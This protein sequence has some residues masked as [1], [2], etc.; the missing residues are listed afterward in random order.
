[1]LGESSRL[2]L[3]VDGS[4]TTAAYGSVSAGGI[5]TPEL[6]VT[7]VV[8][9]HP[10]GSAG[11]VTPSKNSKTSKM[12]LHWPSIRLLPSAAPAAT[13]SNPTT[14]VATR[15]RQMISRSRVGM[16]AICRKTLQDVNRDSG[17]N[18][19]RTIPVKN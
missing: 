2:L 3:I 11:G 13:L 5:G 1:M 8:L 17:Q 10:V 19:R 15:N 7:H 16:N 4:S 14:A 6:D 9:D 12:G 18:P